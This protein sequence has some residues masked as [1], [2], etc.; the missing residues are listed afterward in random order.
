M[1]DNQIILQSIVFSTPSCLKY[2]WEVQM[3]SG[4]FKSSQ[5]HFIASRFSLDAVLFTD[6]YTDKQIKSKVDIPCVTIE[7][8]NEQHYHYFIHT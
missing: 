7:T 3:P 6:I 1:K 5:F 4:T 2:D 8:N